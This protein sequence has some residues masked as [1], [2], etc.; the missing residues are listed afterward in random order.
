MFSFF[1]KP[2]GYFILSKGIFHISL[3]GPLDKNAFEKKL[4]EKN[5][6]LFA[7]ALLPNSDT[8]IPLREDSWSFSELPNK[9]VTDRYPLLSHLC[10]ENISKNEADFYLQFAGSKIG[11]LSAS[12]ATEIDDAYYRI[13]DLLL[14]ATSWK[15]WL[16]IENKEWAQ[17]LLKKGILSSKNVENTKNLLKRESQSVQNLRRA[18]R[19][20]V[21]ATMWVRDNSN[22]K[23]LG[24]CADLSLT[25]SQVLL[26]SNMPMQVGKI[27]DL[28]LRPSKIAANDKLDI[29]V[30]LRGRVVWH[31]PQTLRL[32]IEFTELT[33]NMKSKLQLLIQHFV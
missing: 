31:N 10:A 5:Y 29:H 12:G 21:I 33:P 30:E 22:N 9:W 1:K 16:L 3:D 23:L 19:H 24:A 7:L 15:D 18:E 20:P 2:S 25:G 4:K 27:L 6:P 8:W 13:Y 32:G 17:K 14:R 11:P 26:D 28:I